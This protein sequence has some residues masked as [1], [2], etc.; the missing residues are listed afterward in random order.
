[1]TRIGHERALSLER[2]LDP[3]QHLVQRAA[4]PPNLVEGDRVGQALAPLVEADLARSQSHRLNRPQRQG[5][6]AVA[7]RR[8]YDEGQRTTDRKRGD[9][10]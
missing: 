7:Q 3:L 10:A 6:Q 1:M 2:Q 9:Q 4:E 8:H 5:G